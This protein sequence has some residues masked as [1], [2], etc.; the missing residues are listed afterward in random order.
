MSDIKLPEDLN[1]IAI[2]ASEPL[3]GYTPDQMRE[4]ASKYDSDE[5]LL[6]FM[7]V[8]PTRLAG[9][10]MTLANLKMMKRQTTDSKRNSMNGGNLKKN[11]MRKLFLGYRKRMQRKEP[12]I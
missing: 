6:L 1:K 11:C 3:K 9:S 2:M 10:D 8:F 4:M 7:R 5:A 12:H